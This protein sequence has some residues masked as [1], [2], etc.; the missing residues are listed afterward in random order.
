MRTTWQLFRM[1]FDSFLA[2]D[3]PR[4][5]A[6]LSYY[7]LFS[8]APLLI[9]VLGVAGIFFAPGEARVQLLG[10]IS[11]QAGRQIADIIDGLIASTVSGR[12]QS[13]TVVGVL[14]LA[15]ASTGFLTQ[16]QRTLNAIW[17][18]AEPARH[19]MLQQLLMRAIS[20][21]MV[22]VLG[23]LVILGIG[24]QAGLGVVR[25]L[26]AER[27]PG[28]EGLL[29]A[30]NQV[31]AIAVIALTFVAVVRILTHR[32]VGWKALFAG[33]LLTAVLFRIGEVLIAFYLS[34]SAVSSA[35]G[36]AGSLVA[37]L[38]FIHYS[39]Q[40]FLAG[41]VFTRTFEKTLAGTAAADEAG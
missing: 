4:H 19:G 30:A 39:L 32:R 23:V 1:T 6:A 33:A 21:G 12:Y 34:T 2:L 28:A 25:R 41:V 36:A 11:D 10:A 38:L 15:F 20:L 8:L 13:A 40:I 31:L 18:V 35:F 17:E 5:A 26:L 3:V 27:L 7:A 37:L 16:L 24:L 22:A 14:I 29:L 9:I